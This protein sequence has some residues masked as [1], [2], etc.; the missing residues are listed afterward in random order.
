MEG[1]AVTC[2]LAPDAP[3][4]G[5]GFCSSP[6]DFALDFLQTPPHGDALALR[7][8]FGSAYT[9]C[10]DLHPTRFVSCP[11]HTLKMSYRDPRA[12]AAL[13]TMTS[14]LANPPTSELAP[15]VMN[16]ILAMAVRGG[17]A[18]GPPVVQ[19][20]AVGVRPASGRRRGRRQGARW[21]GPAGARRAA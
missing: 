17:P 5:S 6:R 16:L 21:P 2:P 1:F 12:S 19:T 11:A 20:S 14:P 4:L 9:W 10:R 3:R 18:E 8:T 15:L 13:Q 7:L